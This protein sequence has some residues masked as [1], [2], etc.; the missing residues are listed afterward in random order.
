MRTLD[1]VVLA[2]WLKLMTTSPGRL[3]GKEG[4]RFVCSRIISCLL[5]TH[6]I[7]G[8]SSWSMPC[9]QSLILLCEFAL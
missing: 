4:R 3:D 8:Q 1:A 6:A 2:V 5:L 9:K 7:N